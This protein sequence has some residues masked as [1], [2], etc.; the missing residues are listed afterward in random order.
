METASRTSSPSAGFSSRLIPRLPVERLGLMPGGRV[1]ITDD[2]LGCGGSELASLLEA[3]DIAVHR[4]GGP[5]QPVDWTSPSAVDSVVERLRS[6]GPI[7]GI[8]HTL[9]LGRNRQG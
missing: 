1:I 8:V 3:A 9:P 7:A 2:R 5:D 4:L 6:Q